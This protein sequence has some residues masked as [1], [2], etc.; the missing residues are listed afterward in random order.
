MAVNGLGLGGGVGGHS[1]TLNL[2]YFCCET[3]ICMLL[4][5]FVVGRFSTVFQGSIPFEINHKS[6]F[7]L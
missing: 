5:E 2:V 6:I 3:T 7:Q 4:R 1:G